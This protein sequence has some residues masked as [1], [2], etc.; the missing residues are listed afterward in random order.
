MHFLKEWSFLYLVS[1]FGSLKH[2]RRCV[3]NGFSRPVFFAQPSVSS[4]IWSLFPS[5]IIVVRKWSVVA[6]GSCYAGCDWSRYSNQCG[7]PFC[8]YPLSHPSSRFAFVLY[9]PLTTSSSLIVHHISRICWS[10]V[11]TWLYFIHLRVTSCEKVYNVVTMPGFVR[12]QSRG[13]VPGCTNADARVARA[14]NEA[15]MRG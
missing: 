13:M 2:S 15:M 8:L 5:E 10:R 4:K 3:L 14:V 12:E 7:A 9:S 11:R 1:K 6:N